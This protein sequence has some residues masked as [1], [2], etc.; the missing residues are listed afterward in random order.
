[1]RL[2][3][4][5]ASMLLISNSAIAAPSVFDF[6]PIE[7]DNNINVACKFSCNEEKEFE[8]FRNNYN[9]NITGK[10]VNFIDKRINKVTKSVVIED[11]YTTPVSTGVSITPLADD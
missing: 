3:Y 1:M 9:G 6:S 5:F 2:S 11:I 10:T 7:I 4:L 8:H